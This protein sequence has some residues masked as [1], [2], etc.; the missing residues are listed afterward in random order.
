MGCSSHFDWVTRHCNLIQNFPDQD[1]PR[2][3]NIATKNKSE[4]LS[5]W[6]QKVLETHRFVEKFAIVCQVSYPE[7]LEGKDGYVSLGSLQ[8]SGAWVS[9]P[10]R[11]EVG[12]WYGTL[13]FFLR[14]RIP[15]FFFMLSLNW[16]WWCLMMFNDVWCLMLFGTTISFKDDR[17]EPYPASLR[18]L[19]V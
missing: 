14:V 18:P 16:V 12:T 1:H 17:K 2:S 10:Q 19:F 3:S 13:G 9:W 4:D 7:E 8:G 6:C 15:V 5:P 11:S